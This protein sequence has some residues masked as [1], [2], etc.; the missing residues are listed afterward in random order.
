M[1]L[2]ARKIIPALAALICSAGFTKAQ[3][4]G[5]INGVLLARF[6]SPDSRVKAVAF[7][8]DGKL[9]AAGYGLYVDDGITIWKVADHYRTR[10]VELTS[11]GAGE[12]RSDA[13]SIEVLFRG[14]PAKKREAFSRVFDREEQFLTTLLH[15]GTKLPPN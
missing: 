10:Y 12:L 5:D 3:S 13:D 9:L 6:E 2:I 15:A 1:K 11:D 8:P 7:S 14:G 4:A